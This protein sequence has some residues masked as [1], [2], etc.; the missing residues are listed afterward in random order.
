MN[1]EKMFSLNPN[2]QDPFECE[3][4]DPGFTM[5]N[6]IYTYDVEQKLDL[7]SQSSDILTL[8][9]QLKL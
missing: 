3:N 7:E 4:D 5:S 8:Y 9:K 2:C 1:T 6:F